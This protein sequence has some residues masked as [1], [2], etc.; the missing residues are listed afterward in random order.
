MEWSLDP[1]V[2]AWLL[3]A[4][5][6]YLRALSILRGRGVAVPRLQVLW[7]HLGITLQVIGLLSPLAVLADDLLSAHMAEHLLIADLAAPLLIAGLRNPVLGFFL[8]R[9]LLVGLARRRRLRGAART[10]RRPWLAV[11]LYVVVLYTWHWP[12][13]FEA[14]VRDPFVHAAQ[15]ATFISTA[16]LVWWPAL[17]PKRRRL[18]PEAWKVLHLMG[19]R[20][21]GMPLGMA[22]I[23]M[24]TPVYTGVYASGDRGHGLDAI[25]DQQI[26]G[27]LMM[28][29]DIYLMLFVLA[30]FFYRAAQDA[31]SREST[32]IT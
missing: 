2:L 8:P 12:P 11:P 21:L 30:F 10:V 22:F 5:G 7:W 3:T 9:P 24:R 17:E 25:A 6:L 4:E 27:G 16:V 13:L 26:A 31:G 29:V 14:A 19:A 15:H 20:L 1:G 18:T 32:A 28:A 23:L